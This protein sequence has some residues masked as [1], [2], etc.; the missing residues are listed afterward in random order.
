[1][2][3]PS[4][5]TTPPAV[6]P[7]L[8]PTVGGDLQVP[9]V[10]GGTVRYANLDIAASA[11]ALHSVAERVA[12]FLP[13]YSSV[14]RGAGHGSAVSTA[15]YETARQTVAGFVGARPDDVVQFARHTTDAFNL[16][17]SAVPGEVVTLDVEHHANL[18]P[19]RRGATRTVIAAASVA[20][21]LEAVAAELARTPAALLAVTGASNV[22]GEILP[23]AD[24][25]AIAHRH[26][27]RIAVDGAQ[28]VPHHRVHLAALDIDYLAFSGHKLYAPY[29]TGVLVGRRDWLEAAPP[30]LAGGGAVRAV[31]LDDVTWAGAP[32]RHEAGTPNVVGAVALAAACEALAALPDAA[33]FRH[34]TDL[35]DR[36]HEGLTALPGVRIL[37]LWGRGEAELLGLATFTVDG[38]PAGLVSQYLSA[39]HGIGVRDGRF[40]AHPLLARLNGGATAV[41]ASIGVGTTS[42]DVDRLLRALAELLRNGPSWSYGAD[43]RPHPDPRPL[44]H[45]VGA[46]D[47]VS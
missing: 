8:L 24:L 27:A 18:L 35:R 20:A 9:L 38:I 42:D 32:T 13:Y 43:S 10:T 21:T 44:P 1:M 28:L 2:T 22:T 39:E 37:R 15:A 17:A 3:T 14:H 31:S 34:E 23:L 33:Q 45:W 47:R 46:P 5:A 40:C 4:R 29:G 19:W 7:A 11:P 12:A 41:R 6:V 26:G 25:V 30:Y 16:L 36:L